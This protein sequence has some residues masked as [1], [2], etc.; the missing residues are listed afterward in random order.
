VTLAPFAR[1][2]ALVAL[3]ATSSCRR[4]EARPFRPATPDALSATPAVATASVPQGSGGSVSQAPPPAPPPPAT[5]DAAP[6]P[7]ATPSAPVMP[8]AGSSATPSPSPDAPATCRGAA[9]AQGTTRSVGG[10]TFHVWTPAAYDGRQRL[11]VVVVFHGWYAT[12]KAFQTWFKMEEHVRGEAI[13]VYPDAAGPMWSL[14]DE[15]DTTF[16]AGL[17]DDV[18]ATY[19]ADRA[20]V[21]AFG[22]SFGG[23]F[24]H[25][26]GCTSTKLVKAIAVGDGSLGGG[27]VGCG[28]LPVLVT[29]RTRDDDERF[30]WG[31]T[32]AETWARGNGCTSATDP[33]DPAHG[34]VAFRGCKPGAPVTFCEDTYFNPSWPHDWNHTVREEYR[35]LTWAWFS[36]VP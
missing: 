28:S 8:S 2:V 15:R 21:L 27:L 26:L 30:A 6:P 22:F 3:L 36:K 17:L 12:G 34:C 24:T 10:R 7:S 5:T 9:P 33:I 20:R 32:A 11:P 16:V 25:K 18:A 14:V 4:D 29:H 31:K 1:G 13:V 35:D 19:C 23:K